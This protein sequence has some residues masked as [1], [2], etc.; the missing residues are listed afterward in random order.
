MKVVGVVG[1]GKG[2]DQHC[3]AQL[4]SCRASRN[5]GHV[6]GHSVTPSATCDEGGSG[7]GRLGRR[8]GQQEAGH[9]GLRWG[10]KKQSWS[11]KM[12]Q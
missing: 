2:R 5:D 11:I 10:N 7:R 3:S 1:G 12:G 6:E 9:G 8:G 4:S